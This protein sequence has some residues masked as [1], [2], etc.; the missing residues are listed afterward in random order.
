MRTPLENYKPAASAQTH[1]LLAAAL[2]SVVGGVL[3]IVG[4]RWALARPGPRLAP[5]LVAAAA[6]AGVLKARFVLKRAAERIVC[7]IQERGDGRCIGGFVSLRSWLLVMGMMGTGYLLRHGL[8]PHS[9]VGL[10]YVAIGTALLLASAVIW[11]AWGLG[12]IGT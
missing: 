8:L 11:R 3:L 10:I 9:V 7:R 6:L 2:W 4:G 5:V 12:R 1:L